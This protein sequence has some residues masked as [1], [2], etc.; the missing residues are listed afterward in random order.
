M[1]YLRS[2][3]SPIKVE[4]FKTDID[5]L[6]WIVEKATLSYAKSGGLTTQID[7]EAEN[8]LS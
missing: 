3:P 1:G 8:E 2:L 5:N 4:G 6:K 7:L